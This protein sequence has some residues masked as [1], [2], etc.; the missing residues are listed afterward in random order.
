MNA[1]FFALAFLAALNP[2]LFAVDLLP[3]PPTMRRAS[4]NSAAAYSRST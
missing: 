4:N 1:T 2:N 3:T